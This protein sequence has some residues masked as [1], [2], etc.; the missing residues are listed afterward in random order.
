LPHFDELCSAELLNRKFLVPCDPVNY[1]DRDYGPERWKTPESVN[2]TW[3]N[4]K[5]WEKWSQPLWPHTIKYYDKAGRLIPKR[6]LDYVNKY[7]TVPIT[8]VPLDDDADIPGVLGPM[9]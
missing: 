6:I 1:L 9:D 8:S 2:Y 3:S 5:Y 4:V 7:L